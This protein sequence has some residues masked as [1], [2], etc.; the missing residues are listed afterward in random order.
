MGLTLLC[1]LPLRTASSFPDWEASKEKNMS[2]KRIFY[3]KGTLT[4]KFEGALMQKKLLR[5]TQ[6]SHILFNFGGERGS[7]TYRIIENHKI[8]IGCKLSVYKI[9][10]FIETHRMHFDI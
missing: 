1:S 8:S 6:E 5:G 3:H 7:R 4:N 9:I 10:K 2:F